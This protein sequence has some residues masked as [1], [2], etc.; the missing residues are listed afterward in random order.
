MDEADTQFGGV[1]LEGT[2]HRTPPYGKIQAMAISASRPGYVA[3]M[4]ARI[5]LLPRHPC[6]GRVGG[7]YPVID[8]DGADRDDFIRWMVRPSSGRI[9]MKDT[10][11]LETGHRR[12]FRA[13]F[14]AI[15]AQVKARHRL[16]PQLTLEGRSKPYTTSSPRPSRT[17]AATKPQALVNCTRRSLLPDPDATAEDREA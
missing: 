7:W 8:P 17:P 15:R 16:G 13:S 2:F 12:L 10:G 4:T 6:G 14:A 3:L 5:N 11:R 9:W 1:G